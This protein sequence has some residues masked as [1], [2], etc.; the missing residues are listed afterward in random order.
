MK[1]K[2]TTFTDP[3]MGLSYECE[4][5]FRKLETHFESQIEFKYVMSGLVRDVYDFVDRADLRFG[6]AEAIRRYNKSLAKIYESEEHIS[7]MPIN[8]DSFCLFDSEHTSSLPL[9]LAYKAVQLINPEKTDLFLYNLRYATI[10]DCRPTTHI[11]EILEVIRK[12]GIHVDRFMTAYNDG[13]AQA[14]LDKDLALFKRLGLHSLPAYL[15]QYGEK[16]YL[17]QTFSYTDFLS[18]IDKITDGKIRPQVVE[19]SLENIKRLIEKHPL[20][21]PLEIKEAFDFDSIEEVAESIKSLKNIKIIN[22][23]HGWF[24]KKK[25]YNE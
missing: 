22:V 10:V 4:P 15:I 9:N 16:G 5:M 2:I 24:I 14:E 1:V 21:S 23:P 3:M 12:T 18:V 13:S 8:M 19:R 20:M 17:I 7:G 11:E 25:G 6:K